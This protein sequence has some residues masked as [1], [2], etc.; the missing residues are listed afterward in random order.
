MITALLL[1]LKPNEPEEIDNSNIIELDQ[2]RK[3]VR[4]QVEEEL[5]VVGDAM[6]AAA[7]TKVS[8]KTSKV[9]RDEAAERARRTVSKVSAGSFA[10]QLAQWRQQNQ[11]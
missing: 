4:V 5:E 8:R 10:E 7:P 2:N 3:T 11:A 1:L 6:E 9:E